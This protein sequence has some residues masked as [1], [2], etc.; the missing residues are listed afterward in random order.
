VIFL[1]PDLREGRVACHVDRILRRVSH[2]AVNRWLL[3]RYW[4]VDS[5]YGGTLN[6]LRHCEVAQRAGLAAV[7]ATT[8]GHDGYGDVLGTGRQLP[9]I[10]WRER[11]EDDLCIIPD[12]ASRLV[13]DVH[14]A[15]VVYQQSPLHLHRDFDFTRSNV[16][17]WTDSPFMLEKC[18]AMFPDKDITIVPNV[19]DATMFPFVPQGLREPGLLF[20]FPRKNPEFID[21]TWREYTRRGGSYWR[22]ER[23]H[24]LT[25]QQLAA[26][27]REP[28][29]FLASAQVEGCALPPQ[30]SMS[31]GVMVIGRSAA[32]ANFAMRHR[33]TALIAETPEAAADQLFDAEAPA[34]REQI[35]L[36]AREH[37]GRFF[38]E[39]EPLSFWRAQG[40]QMAMSDVA[41]HGNGA[42]SMGEIWKSPG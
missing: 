29:A 4:V 1:V 20:A 7:V 16:S 14:G 13:D 42:G 38:P 6:L 30:E 26:R 17:I 39:A 28:Q 25:I 24:G 21:A 32:G 3:H 34:L 31:A 23:V 37:I 2:A 19:V 9:V 33:E 5:V 11:R 35:T 40:R 18:Q 15:V 36:K 12:Y 8:S 27:F 41:A 22:L 10:A